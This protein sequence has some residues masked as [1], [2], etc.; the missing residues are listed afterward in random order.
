MSYGFLIEDFLR[1]H[2]FECSF[3]HV[4]GYKTHSKAAIEKMKLVQ[5]IR[6]FRAVYPK[7]PKF[8]DGLDK[9][10]LIR[11]RLTHRL[12]DQ[13]GSDVESEEGR[14]QI[15]ALLLRTI[16]HM[17]HHFE[18]LQRTHEAV[19]RIAIKDNWEALLARGD[20]L[21]EARVSTSEIQ[22][23]L[24]DLDELAKA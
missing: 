2:L 1:L 3:N 17:K 6:E 7:Q 15:H 4:N 18:A 22:S 12:I 23:L 5:L 21:F 11:N 19:V 9:I 13:F 20:E 16:F 8:S 10:R 14:D 24:D